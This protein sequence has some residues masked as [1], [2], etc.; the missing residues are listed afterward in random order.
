MGN[1]MSASFAPECTDA[2]KAYDNCFNEWYSEKFLKAKSVTN[3]CEDTWREYE[4][5]IHTALEKKGIKTMLND[6]RKDAPFEKGGISQ[7]HETTPDNS[8]VEATSK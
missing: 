5:C 3:E 2:K 1:I 8:K 6:A 7:A 4:S